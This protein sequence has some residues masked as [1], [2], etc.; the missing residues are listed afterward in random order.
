MQKTWNTTIALG[1]LL[2][3]SGLLFLPAA[4]N[5]STVD[6]AMLAGGLAVFATG[7]MLVSCSF[8]F[9]AKLMHKSLAADPNVNVI[10][11]AQKRKGPC[12]ACHGGTPVIYCTMHKV[13]LCGTCLAQHYD[14]RGCVYTPAVRKSVGRS[15]RS[16][17]AGRS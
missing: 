5:S 4:L 1:I 2:M 17:A 12:D 16:T 11:N 15:V 9:K 10:L 3:F 6:E 14:A 13:T 8:Y 7:M